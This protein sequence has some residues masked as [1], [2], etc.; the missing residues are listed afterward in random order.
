MRFVLLI[1]EGKEAGREFNFEQDSVVIGRTEDC[2]VVLLEAGVS[3]KH[4][5]IFEAA[6]GIQIEDLGS[7][8]GTKINGAVV[9]S[10]P[11]TT[12]DSIGI[13]PVV[14]KFTSKDAPARPDKPEDTDENLGAPLDEGDQSTRIIS[15]EEVARK[16][17]QL[18]EKKALVENNPTDKRP[19]L[20]AKRSNSKKGVALARVP[21]EREDSRPARLSAVDRARIRRRNAGVAGRASIAWAEASSSGRRNLV[22]VALAGLAALGG[23]GY[24]LYA[25]VLHP[26]DEK[27]L[28]PEPTTLDSKGVAQ[29][30]GLGPDV[31]YQTPS[32]KGF[33]FD[34]RSPV[35][36]IL[37]LRY[38]S[39]NISAEEVTIEVNGTPVGTVQPDLADSANHVWETIIPS[40]ALKRNEVNRITF[41]NT[42][43]PPGSDTWK[44][45]GIWV[46]ILPLSDDP[47]DRLIQDARLLTRNADEK[48]NQAS[49]GSEN[50]YLAWQKYRQAWL[51]LESLPPERRPEDYE[52]VRAKMR[53]TQDA[54]NLRC[55]ALILDFM[56]ALHSGDL[57]KARL[58]LE[59]VKDFFPRGD[60]QCFRLADALREAYQL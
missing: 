34:F 11:L 26:D 47:D 57:T 32:E 1:A 37:S 54:L 24:Y 16:R 30:F 42:H 21:R 36:A 14:F 59:H 55:N 17:T 33:D 41:N 6:G 60:Q 29:S 20:L 56:R 25:N 13:G 27:K 35:R 7:S 12:G 43:N 44:V 2:D 48:A 15:A 50:L 22:L 38:S 51:K 19:A 49:V 58:S 28:G 8:N 45:G 9:K 10:K 31:D 3:R 53:N 23:G 5:R 4:A 52:R 46:E 40:E 39:K 18:A